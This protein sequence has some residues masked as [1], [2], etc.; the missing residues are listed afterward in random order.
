[1]KTISFQLQEL[2]LNTLEIDATNLSDTSATE[3]SI[4]KLNQASDVIANRITF[5]DTQISN[6]NF[7]ITNTLNNRSPF[8]GAN[9]EINSLAEA[10]SNTSSLSANILQGSSVNSQNAVSRTNVFDL[11]EISS[12][13]VNLGSDETYS[14]FRL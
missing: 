8:N 13:S 4:T 11:L 9:I 12:P 1:G 3:Q 2:S 14:T 7:H 5:V 6:I 10:R